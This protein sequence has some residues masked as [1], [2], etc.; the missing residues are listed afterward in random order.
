MKQF[1][2]VRLTQAAATYGEQV[3][4]TAVCCNACRTCATTNL[5]G[6]A[7]VALAGIGASIARVTARIAKRS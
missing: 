7:T 3:P 5:V 2:T 4:M 1:A 6:L